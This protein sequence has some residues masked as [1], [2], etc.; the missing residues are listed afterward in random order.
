LQL[1]Y[2]S[3]R[4]GP[5][6]SKNPAACMAASISVYALYFFFFHGAEGEDRTRDLRFTIPLLYQLS[7]LGLLLLLRS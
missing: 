2:K 1:F 7:Y 5:G 6:R 4:L 3:L